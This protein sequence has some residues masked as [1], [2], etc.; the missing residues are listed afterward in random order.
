MFPVR[1]FSFPNL[2]T[3][4]CVYLLDKME[5]NALIILRLILGEKL[6]T[7]KGP[8]SQYFKFVGY[9]VSVTTTPVYSSGTKS[10][11]KQYADEQDKKTDISVLDYQ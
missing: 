9:K 2:P 6:I 7:C 10:S 8:D 5:F 1:K 11:H 3:Y 4:K